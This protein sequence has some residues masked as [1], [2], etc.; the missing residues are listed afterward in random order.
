MR[1]AHRNERLIP[2]DGGPDP[3]LDAL[4]AKVDRRLDEGFLT[5]LGA[6]FAR[7]DEAE[8]R[9]QPGRLAK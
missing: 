6:V 7:G 1:K 4:L 9:A 2:P 5:E 8:S 3:E